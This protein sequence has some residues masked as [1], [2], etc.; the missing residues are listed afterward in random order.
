[1]TPH[2]ENLKLMAERLTWMATRKNNIPAMQTCIAQGFR[3]IA[4]CLEKL[5]DGEAR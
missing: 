3:D 5:R 2:I 1:M 4:A